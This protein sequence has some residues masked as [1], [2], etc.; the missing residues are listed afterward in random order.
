MKRWAAPRTGR[1]IPACAAS[2]RLVWTGRPVFAKVLAEIRFVFLSFVPEGPLSFQRYVLWERRIDHLSGP[3]QSPRLYRTD[4]QKTPQR[5]C[6]SIKAFSCFGKFL[7]A[8]HWH[9]TC[10]FRLIGNFRHIRT[11]RSV[12]HGK[13]IK[14]WRAQNKSG[15]MDAGGTGNAQKKTFQIAYRGMAGKGLCASGIRRR[16]KKKNLAIEMLSSQ[17][18]KKWFILPFRAKR[19]ISLR[20]KPRRREIPRRAARRGMTKV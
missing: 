15:L 4:R 3:R 11:R 7:N 19:G 8:C 1:N 2:I 6:K 14:G 20:L 13:R 16:L 12:K 18:R 17:L 5:Q 9:F 10:F